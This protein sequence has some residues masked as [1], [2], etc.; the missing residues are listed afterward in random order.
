MVSAIR[1]CWRVRPRC[2]GLCSL[3]LCAVA[4]L[5]V[6][7]V[8]PAAREAVGAQGYISG[9]VESSSGPEAGVWVIAETEELG[10]TFAKIVVTDDNGRFVLPELPD[11]TY[12]VWV[13]GYGLV[14][15]RKVRLSPD[16]DGVA[17]EAVIAPTAAD[18]AQYYPGNYWY[19]LIEPPPKSDFPGTGPDGNGISKA[20][21]SQAAWVDQMKQSCQFCHQLGNE[22]TRV[23]R[24]RDDF[25][26]AVAAWDH[27]V[28]TGQRGNQMSS[29]MSRFGRQRALEMFADWTERIAAGE[30]PPPP[31][32]PKGLERNVVVTLWDW[33]QE[34]SFIHDEVVTDKRTPTVNAN[35]PVYGVS[36]GHGTITV[37]DPIADTA[38]E[39]TIPVRP[40]PETM[41][42]RFPQEQVN[43]S[44][45]WGEE[46]HWGVEPSERS[47]PHNPMMDH[48]GR[49]WMTSTVRQ[50]V[51]PDWCREGS[52][53]PYAQYFPLSRAG[54]HASYY[55][56]ADERFALIHTATARITFSLVRT[57]TTRCGLAVTS[58]RSGG[59]TRVSMTRPVT[60]RSP[61]AGARPSSIPTATGGSPGRGTSRRVGVT[62]SIRTRVTTRGFL[63]SATA[64][65]RARSTTPSGSRGPG[66]FRAVSCAWT[67]VITHPRP[68]WRRSTSLR[69]SRT[70][71]STRRTPASHLGASTLPETG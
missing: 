14:D 68:V 16:R 55:D 21:Q 28:Q 20:Y 53:N 54:R 12:D 57:T 9:V 70:R 66:R 32:R 61:R 64:S 56:P 60:S 23:V 29:A 13:R 7:M 43:P 42:T 36:A 19:S 11:A 24:H 17:L 5:M 6:T 50:F 63:A 51:N 25:D 46:I 26:S 2:F 30:L 8:T 39:L 10:T 37:V 35:G 49:V 18:A 31:P 40:D 4:A 27:R 71:T 48:K 22:A 58:T 33:G 45:Y 47:D 38:T 62:R 41:P 67:A 69:P 59:S 44:Y 52:D 65:S 15:P 3:V 1:S 34:T